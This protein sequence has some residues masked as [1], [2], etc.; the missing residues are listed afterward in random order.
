MIWTLGWGR[1]HVLD[2]ITAANGGWRVELRAP[3]RSDAQNR[4]LW[5][6][7]GDIARQCRLNAGEYTPEQWKCVFLRAMHREMQFLPDLNGGFFPAGFRS[8]T[9]TVAEMTALQDF[10]QAYGDEQGVAWSD[11]SQRQD[12]GH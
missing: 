2:A 12:D 11:P 7:L 5:A 4:R 3:K 1:Q 9:L 6:M 10:M 8:S